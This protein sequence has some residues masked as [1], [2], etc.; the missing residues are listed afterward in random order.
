MA[1]DIAQIPA[2]AARLLADRDGAVS[3]VVRAAA[4]RRPGLVVFVGRGSSF[5]AALYGRYLVE[6]LLG[7]PVVM[8]SPVVASVFGS[9]VR[10]DGALVLALSQ[11]GRSPDILAT[12]E[13]AKRSASLTVSVVNDTASPLATL[14][15]LVVPL[16]VGEEA[17]T[18]TKSYVAEI[19]ALAEIVARW[20]P[21]KDLRAALARAP[22]A[23]E[24]TLVEGIS[25]LDANPELVAEFA[26]ADRAQIVG[27]GYDFATA[28][29]VAIKLTE[30][31]AIM[32]IGL[33]ASDF[34]HGFAVPSGQTV[35]LLAF[36]PDGAAGDSVDAAVIEASSRGSVPWIVGGAPAA[37]RPR[38]LSLKHG[39][40]PELAPLANVIPGY[41]LAERTARARGRDPDAPEGL[42]KVIL[43]T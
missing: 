30:T 31:A 23:L 38:G 24:R 3:A 19:V 37:A 34:H 25:L 20:S 35:P 2:A 43:T 26:A 33:S 29:E 1:G 14:G 21:R 27:R 6:T 13:A 11:G 41:M 22:E 4:A 8:A 18:A 15:E 17:V 36:R 12:V 16:G 42:Q 7:L 9:P 28:L 39:L 40:P 10:Y 5:Y 32:A